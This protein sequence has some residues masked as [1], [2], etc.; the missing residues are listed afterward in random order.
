[1]KRAIIIHSA[2]SL[3]P[4]RLVISD[5]PIN[6]PAHIGNGEN[7]FAVA[8]EDL[9]FT[10]DGAVTPECLLRLVSQFHGVD[11]TDIPDDRCAV[12]CRNTGLVRGMIKADPEIDEHPH[13]NVVSAADHVRVNDKHDGEQ[14]LSR[15]AVCNDDRVAGFI[16]DVEIPTELEG[17]IVPVAEVANIGDAI[18]GDN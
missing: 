9:I 3:I 13:G 6:V 12:I 14:F 1:M 2:N 17:L 8:F 4:R 7:G 11:H 15:F 16:W 18:D 5:D 10:E